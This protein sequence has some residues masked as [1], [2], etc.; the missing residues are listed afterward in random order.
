MQAALI[1]QTSA[2]ARAGIAGDGALQD[3]HCSIIVQA[4]SERMFSGGDVVAAY[5]GVDDPCISFIG[6]TSSG[7]GFIVVDRA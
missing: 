4:S 1:A 3:F 7:K 6:Y 5:G 2:L